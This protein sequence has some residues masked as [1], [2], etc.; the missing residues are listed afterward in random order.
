MYYFSFI[1]LK[2]LTP[3]IDKKWEKF[4]LLLIPDLWHKR[5]I[6]NN[7]F[8]EINSGVPQGDT[9]AP[10]LYIITFAP[11]LLTT[12]SE[13]HQTQTKSF[14]HFYNILRLDDLP[15]FVFTTSKTKRDY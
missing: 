5:L 15:I 8:F 12:S 11:Y 14:N 10:Y 3:S 9:L 1:S 6:G 7:E 13:E 2:L 4:C